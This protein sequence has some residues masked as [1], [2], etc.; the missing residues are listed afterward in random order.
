MSNKL[1]LS[2]PNAPKFLIIFSITIGEKVTKSSNHH[3]CLLKSG[4]VLVDK[5]ERLNLWDVKMLSGEDDDEEFE[6]KL[7]GKLGF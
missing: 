1:L 5:I 2:L 6:E 7:R 3:D 4:V